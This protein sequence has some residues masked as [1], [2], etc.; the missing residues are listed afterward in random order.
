MYKKYEG[1]AVNGMIINGMYKD[2]DAFTGKTIMVF[3]IVSATTREVLFS[4]EAESFISRHIENDM[5]GRY[6]ETV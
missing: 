3:V 6:T 1:M 5:C 2:F 4:E